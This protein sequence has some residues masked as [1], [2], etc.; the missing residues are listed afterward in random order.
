MESSG[1]KSTLE[2]ENN[3]FEIGFAIRCALI[4][5]NALPKPD[6][7]EC[8]CLSSAYCLFLFASTVRM[9]R[10]TWT[11]S[12]NHKPIKYIMTGN[13]RKRIERKRKV[14]MLEQTK[15]LKINANFASRLWRAK[16][17]RRHCHCCCCTSINVQFSFPIKADSRFLS[18]ELPFMP[19]LLVAVVGSGLFGK[20]CICI[21]AR[22]VKWYNY[23]RFRGICR[24]QSTQ[25]SLAHTLSFSR[26]PLANSLR[27]LFSLSV[28]F[29]SPVAGVEQSANRR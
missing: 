1:P 5:V 18:A 16:E 3:E 2:F 7:R 13:N 25:R 21:D 14:K 10:R 22:R 6:R 15:F 20:C 24:E 12:L 11:S 19:L 9:C 17:K 4:F 8:C 27:A 29:I 28:K 26:S 23:K